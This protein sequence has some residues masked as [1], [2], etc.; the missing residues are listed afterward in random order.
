MI[1]ADV[2]VEDMN[3]EQINKVR[4][5]HGKPGIRGTKKDKQKA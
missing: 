4:K 2:K 5:K 1:K 3:E